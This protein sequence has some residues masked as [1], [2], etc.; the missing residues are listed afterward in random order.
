MDGPTFYNDDTLFATYMAHRQH[1][2]NPPDTLERP[3]FLDLVGA[4]GGLRILD[5]ECGGASFGRA[6]LDQGCHIY[7]GVEGSHNMGRCT[8]YC[9]WTRRQGRPFTTHSRNKPIRPTP[10]SYI[11]WR[12]S[13]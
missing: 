1:A 6:A 10:P 11:L 13:G 4:F 5:L 7:L 2:D 9:V 3:V 8:T 12:G